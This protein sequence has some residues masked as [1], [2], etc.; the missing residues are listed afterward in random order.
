MLGYILL[1]YIYLTFLTIYPRLQLQRCVENSPIWFS[2]IG[3]YNVCLKIK[4]K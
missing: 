1:P 3:S 2:Y 4:K